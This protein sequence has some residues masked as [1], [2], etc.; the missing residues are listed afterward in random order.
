MKKIIHVVGARPNFMK[1]A[2]VM[3]ALSTEAQNQGRDF[4]Q[5]LVHTGQHY[6]PEMSSL[7]FDELGLPEPN[8]NLEIGSGGHGQQTGRIMEAFEQV[9]FEEEPD[10]VLVVGDVNSTIACAL[11]AK[12]LGIEVIHVEA[13]LRSGDL[14]MPEEINRI[15]T[16]A[17][18]DRL[19]ITEES[20]T[21]NLAKEGVDP[22]R[23]YF[24]GNVMI[25]SLL[26]HREAALA[27]DTL[28][29][30]SLPK[31]GYG[32]VTMHRPSNVDDPARLAEII[33]AISDTANQLPVLWPIHPRTRG[34]AERFDLADKLDSIENLT[35]CGPL[36][37]LDFLNCTAN[38]RLV[39]TDSGGIQEET[40][41]LGVPCITARGNTERPITIT[42][43]TNQLVAST[44]DAIHEAV[45][46]VLQTK[47]NGDPTRVPKYWDGKAG[48][49]IAKQL[50][51]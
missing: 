13:G 47:A 22:S 36:G 18:S 14:S 46:G 51:S 10:A 34:A 45:T 9:L 50:L 25:D 49:R 7:F 1:V 29:Q 20:A 26:K 43:G 42:Q 19:F 15:L 5:I 41:I 12:K 30:F 48:A 23:I 40:T 28:E 11:D 8:I 17:I 21:D 27:R 37:Y 32:L 31:G 16:D 2:P 44:R 6:S 24:V 4:E 38:S 39:L 3:D 35:L 33:N